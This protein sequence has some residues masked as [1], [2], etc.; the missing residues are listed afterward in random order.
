MIAAIG[1]E[2]WPQISPIRVLPERRNEWEAVVN[3]GIACPHK[4]YIVR[5]SEI[6]VQFINY[7]QK[8]VLERNEAI[9]RVA[10]HCCISL[11]EARGL[12]SPVYWPLSMP[13]LPKGLDVEDCV[14]INVIS[15]EG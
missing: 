6:G 12:I 13:T 15:V 1:A 4:V 2:W 9:K 5:A 7:F 3:F 14:S 10:Q 11:E 8:M